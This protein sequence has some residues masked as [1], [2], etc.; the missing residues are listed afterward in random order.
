MTTTTTT[1]TQS[2]SSFFSSNNILGKKRPRNDDAACNNDDDDAVADG[3]IND[4]GAGR[5]PR[6]KPF[7]A[8]VSATA[9]VREQLQFS[10]QQDVTD[11]RRRILN[12]AT[13]FR[14]L[15]LCPW[16]QTATAMMTAVEASAGT[17][18]SHL[19]RWLIKVGNP[20]WFTIGL[21]TAVQEHHHHLVR[22]LLGHAAFWP[23]HLL[24]HNNHALPA[25]AASRGGRGEKG[26]AGNKK[27]NRST[28][29][30]N[31]S[32]FR[33]LSSIAGTS[34]S[35]ASQ[36]SRK[37][38]LQDPTWGPFSADYYG[39]DD[40]GEDDDAAAAAAALV[41]PECATDNCRHSPALLMLDALL[42]GNQ[43]AAELIMRT[44]VTSAWNLEGSW[45]VGDDLRLSAAEHRGDGAAVPL[46]VIQLGK[47]RFRATARVPCRDAADLVGQVRNCLRACQGK[48]SGFVER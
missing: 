15:E 8:L 17:E 13:D 2:S 19:V 27:K 22:D 24:L 7:T 5:S 44:F 1:T 10:E 48:M 14:G 20:H 28:L 41:V 21:R 42:H 35:S 47:K 11:L 23:E 40:D 43:V 38:R 32:V 6:K 18:S 33:A 12:R 26:A 34:S 9:A 25:A 31:H 39:K 30:A 3:T 36:N 45:S 37:I 16:A 46:T 4:G 29:A